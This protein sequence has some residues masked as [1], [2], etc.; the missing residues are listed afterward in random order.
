MKA[1][2]HKK[3]Y[4]KYGDFNLLVYLADAID[5]GTAINI[6]NCVQSEAPV[7]EHLDDFVTQ[8]AEMWFS[9]ELNWL[10]VSKI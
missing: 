8:F 6:A 3:P 10:I 5:I 7:E 1:N 9:N 4:V 2:K